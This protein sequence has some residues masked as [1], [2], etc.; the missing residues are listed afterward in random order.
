MRR[1]AFITALGGAAAWPFAARAQQ[2]SDLTVGVL[3]GSAPEGIERYLSGFA[4][5]LAETGTSRERTSQSSTAGHAANMICSAKWRT[6]S[7]A[8]MW[9]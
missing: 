2:R 5:G 1:R 6:T 4:H 9:P 3:G 8:V 7:L